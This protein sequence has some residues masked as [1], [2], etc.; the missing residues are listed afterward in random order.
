[1]KTVSAAL[2]AV[3]LC[4]CADKPVPP[5]RL[6][7]PAAVLMQAPGSLPDLREGDD[8]GQHAVIVRKM[9]GKEANKLRRLQRYVRTVTR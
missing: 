4:G 3:F 1:M 7:K 2:A 6:A 8:I 9:Y 5:S